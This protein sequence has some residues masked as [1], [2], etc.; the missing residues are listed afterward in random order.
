VNDD[1]FV[2]RSRSAAQTAVLGVVVPIPEPWS[3]LFVDWRA[4]VGD[5]QATSVPPHVTLL[6]PTEV[7]LAD[8]PVISAHLAEVAANHPPF[9]MH[10]SGTGTFA[11]VSAVVFVA[12]ARGIGNCELIA[13][14]VRRGPLA[15]S[16]AF[17]YHPH[18]TVAHNV[19]GDMLDLA[20]S[21]LSDLSAEFAVDAFTEFEQTPAGAWAVAREYTLTGSPR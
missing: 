2:P 1:T 9:D 21:G 6:P 8:R 19:P 5:P 4:K 14:D 11:P 20:Y 3:Q 7:P 13:N 18:V 10:L 17:P 16:L 15:R 12:V